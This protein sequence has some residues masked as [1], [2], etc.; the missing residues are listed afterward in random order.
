M[1]LQELLE[2]LSPVIRFG[3]SWP[4]GRWP[5]RG[6]FEPAAL[7]IVAGAILT[8]NTRW[9]NVE[10]ALERLRRTLLTTPPVLA[11]ASREILEEAIRPA[12]FYRRKAATL[13]RAAQFFVCHSGPPTREELLDLP[14]IGPETADSI[15]LYA[16]GQPI[17]VVDAYTRRLLTR[18]GLATPDMNYEAVRRFCE[19]ELPSEP[20]LYQRFHALIVEHGKRYCSRRPKCPECPLVS[21]CRWAATVGIEAAPAV[22]LQEEPTGRQQVGLRLRDVNGAET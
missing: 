2:T 22:S 12:G 9:E 6:G 21:C 15:L 16:F 8:Q 3:E 19:V 7:E 5:V 13:Q 18:L 4:D 20:A 10:S 1:N 11:E 14:G 17:F